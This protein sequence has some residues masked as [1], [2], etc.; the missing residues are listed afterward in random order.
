MAPKP[1]VFKFQGVP[2]K[3]RFH[4]DYP[5]IKDTDLGHTNLGE[6]LRIFNKPM[7][8]SA[9]VSSLI[10]YGLVSVTSHLVSIQSSKLIMTLAK[11]F[12]PKERVVRSV[13]GEVVI[14]L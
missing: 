10:Q 11:H 3:S 13:T 5:E 4:D 9:L 6:F 2:S 8:I 14:D 1:I 12:V 7:K